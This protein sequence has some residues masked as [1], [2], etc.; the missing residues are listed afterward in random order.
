MT[1]D[2]GCLKHKVSLESS[3]LATLG[4]TRIRLRSQGKRVT[5]RISCL[6]VCMW[7]AMCFS[8]NLTGRKISLEPENLNFVFFC[9]LVHKKEYKC[10]MTNRCLMFLCCW[11]NCLASL[12]YIQVPREQSS[13]RNSVFWF[14]GKISQIVELCRTHSNSTDFLVRNL[15]AGITWKCKC[16]IIVSDCF[17]KQADFRNLVDS[18]FWAFLAS[19]SET[20]I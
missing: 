1:C 14:S 17:K 20:Y 12:T 19:A 3:G 6:Q 5:F 16:G 4:L 8:Q 18:V 7:T 9:L 10:S 15:I 2:K 13:E 11:M